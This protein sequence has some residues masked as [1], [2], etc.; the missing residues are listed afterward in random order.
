MRDLLQTPSPSLFDAPPPVCYVHAKEFVRWCC[1]F[2][3]QFRNSP[4]LANLR[5]WARKNAIQIS[6]QD[7]SEILDTARP[8]FSR[9][10]EQAVR[11]FEREIVTQ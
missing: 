9:R 5:Y 4:D 2:G 3:A 1:G 11:K 7:E 6:D 8:L 10:V